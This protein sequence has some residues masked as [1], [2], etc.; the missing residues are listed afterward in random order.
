LTAT[1]ESQS[2]NVNPIRTIESHTQSDNRTLDMQSVQRRGPDGQFEPYQ[3]IEKET[4]RVYAATVRTTTHT[5]GLDADGVKT[6]VEVIEEE[7][8]TLEFAFK[9]FA[10]PE[11]VKVEDSK[12]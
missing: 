2:D 11:N 9:L 8:H 6:L 7:K 5:F 12:P 10:E 1:T 3:D 4:V